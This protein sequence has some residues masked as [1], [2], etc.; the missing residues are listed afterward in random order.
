MKGIDEFDVGVVKKQLRGISREITPMNKYLDA[1]T[2]QQVIECVDR[3]TEEV[4]KTDVLETYMEMSEGIKSALMSL[5]GEVSAS[6]YRKFLFNRI[7][8]YLFVTRWYILKVEGFEVGDEPWTVSEEQKERERP[9]EEE[10]ETNKPKL[11]EEITQGA[12]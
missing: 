6:K 10:G 3:V 9:P 12:F 11:P 8:G 1:N 4:K 7:H 5:S 2:K